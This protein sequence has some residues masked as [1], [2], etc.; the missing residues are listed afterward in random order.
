MRPV[1]GQEFDHLILIRSASTDRTEIC[2]RIGMLGKCGAKDFA[3]R[4]Y[5]DKIA[6]ASCQMP[7]F[8]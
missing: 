4:N 2:K 5:F 1:T 7:F 8:L 3:C 6:L